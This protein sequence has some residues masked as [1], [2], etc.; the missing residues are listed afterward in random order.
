MARSYND[1][2][3]E[4]KYLIVDDYLTV[5]GILYQNIWLQAL[6]DKQERSA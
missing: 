1:L 3:V 5:V 4:F 2:G 6:A